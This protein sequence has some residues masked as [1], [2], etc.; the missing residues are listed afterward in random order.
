MLFVAMTSTVPDTQ[1]VL[2][3]HSQRNGWNRFLRFLVSLIFLHLSIFRLCEAFLDSCRPSCLSGNPTT[4]RSSVESSDTGPTLLGSDHSSLLDGSVML[5]HPVF[6]IF[7]QQRNVTLKRSFALGLKC[8]VSLYL[9]LKHIF[10]A[11]SLA[12]ELHSLPDPYPAE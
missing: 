2:N 4:P 6:T 9:R 5:L 10:S 12:L 3:T 7:F 8:C 11:I 1:Q